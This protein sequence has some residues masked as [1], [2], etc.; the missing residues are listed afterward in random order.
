MKKCLA[1]QLATDGSESPNVALT[2]SNIGATLMVKEGFD[3]AI[4]F[5]E[6]K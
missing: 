4:E 5:Y 6:K 3:N 2:Y 1:I